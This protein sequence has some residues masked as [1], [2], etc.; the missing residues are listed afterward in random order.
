MI[1]LR[2]SMEELNAD[3]SACTLKFEQIVQRKYGQDKDL[4]G[5]WQY[6]FRRA[7][8]LGTEDS[9]KDAQEALKQI[10]EHNK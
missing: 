1:P 5:A 4:F 9:W 7:I 2:I 6:S 8:Q 10:M 3:L